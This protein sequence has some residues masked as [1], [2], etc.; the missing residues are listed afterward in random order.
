MRLTSFVAGGDKVLPPAVRGTTHSGNIHLADWWATFSWML[1]L[2]ATGNTAANPGN[3]GASNTNGAGSTRSTNGAARGGGVGPGTAVPVPV[4]AVDGVPVWESLM[5]PNTTAHPRFEVSCSAANRFAHDP[6]LHMHT[7]LDRHVKRGYILHHRWRALTR[8]IILAQTT[9]HGALICGL[10]L[11]TPLPPSCRCPSTSARA[12]TSTPLA[13]KPT[14]QPT[15]RPAASRAL[16][17][18]FMSGARVGLDRF[19]NE[20]VRHAQPS[21][22]LERHCT[23]GARVELDLLLLR[24]YVNGTANASSRGPFVKER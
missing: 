1:G 13:C 10:I 5:T 9:N 4:P 7:T 15:P 16:E 3:P 21:H 23:S 20:L 24:C 14:A 6:S 11:D 17:R 8:V 18:H 19:K 22:V 12:A 2:D